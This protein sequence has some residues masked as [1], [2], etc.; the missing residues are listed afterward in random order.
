MTTTTE[1]R[2]RGR[3]RKD[4][5]II[6][7]RG[8]G[9]IKA[10][11]PVLG[12]NVAVTTH[13]RD[14]VRI[15]EG[16]CFDW[17]AWNRRITPDGFYNAASRNPFRFPQSEG[18]RPGI[19]SFYSS[20]GTI[21]KVLDALVE[22]Y[23][24]R[25]RP[26]PVTLEGS[27]WMRFLASVFIREAGTDGISRSR[28]EKPEGKVWA[29]VNVLP[30]RGGGYNYT[31]EA[32]YAVVNMI[33]PP[34]FCV[35][36]YGDTRFS[37]ADA[38]LCERWKPEDLAEAV[39]AGLRGKTRADSCEAANESPDAPDLTQEPCAI[40]SEAQ[41]TSDVAS[42]QTP[43]VSD[44]SDAVSVDEST[45]EERAEEEATAANA[46]A[47]L[48]SAGKTWGEIKKTQVWLKGLTT[49]K[50]LQAP[51]PLSRILDT[52]ISHEVTENLTA[53][54]RAIA[55]K[56][57]RY[58]FKRDNLHVWY[59]TPVFA[60]RTVGVQKS[61]IVGYTGL[62]CLD[63]DGMKTPE[64]AENVRDDIFM[65]FKEVL[66]AATSASGLGVYVL[67]MLDFDNTEA[68][69]R[70]ALSAAFEAF[71]AKGYMPDT[72]CVDPN[73]ARYLSS[74]AD[75]LSRPDDYIPKAFS[76]NTD[77]TPI[78]PASMLRE[79]WTNSG[80]KRKGAGKAY[81]DEALTRIERAEDGTKDTTLTS[82]MG[83]VARLI[84]NYGLDADKTYD[85]VRQIAAECG[86]DTK[87]TEDKI[88]RLGVRDEK[89]G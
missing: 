59:P 67:I 57:V 28:F 58:D 63:F 75:A 12:A 86:Y 72:G 82:V 38:E 64:D 50:E 77:G 74:D 73:R 19:D 44:D 8:C 30:D 68:G 34:V 87:K 27:Y 84:R 6:F 35:R 37:A 2:K 49:S 69:Y 21:R 42:G 61:N 20:G 15:H 51:A 52:V 47:E 5:N 24:G 3:P 4:E 18:Y 60:E 45:K 41:E 32:W 10:W 88:R 22:L 7:Y 70:A 80:R 78:L 76:A 56:K 36:V 62:A 31:E 66:F 83:T 33:R 26:E 43:P 14:T 25:L 17:T 9:R 65:E 23:D 71:E 89:G 79:C 1:T 40:A 16:L 54:C 39:L 11:N 53:E 29:S 46:P 55:D 85:R 48:S 13:N 81:L